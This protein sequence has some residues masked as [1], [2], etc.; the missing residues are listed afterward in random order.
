MPR[1]PPPPTEIRAG[2]GRRRRVRRLQ[3][4]RGT[5]R[6]RPTAVPPASPAGPRIRLRRMA[7]R[8]SDRRSYFDAT[9]ILVIFSLR[10]PLGVEM[11]TSSPRLPPSRALPTGD[12]F[13]RRIS[14]GSAS[15]EPTT[16]YLVDLP[17]ASLTC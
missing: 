15:A 2:D 12:S 1:A 14:A 3:T 11:T 8:P 4:R 10:S 6:R 5:D 16:V 9:S 17:A 13:D 7:P